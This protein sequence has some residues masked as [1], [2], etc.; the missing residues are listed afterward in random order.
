[1]SPF[2]FFVQSLYPLTPP[3]AFILL[4]VYESVPLFPVSSVFLLDSTYES[5]Y[6]E[7][8]QEQWSIFVFVGFVW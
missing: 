3:L 2:S 8:L 7:S 5:D 4:S 6:F 1:M